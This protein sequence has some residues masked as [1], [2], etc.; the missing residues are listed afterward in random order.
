MGAGSLQHVSQME[1]DLRLELD[2]GRNRWESWHSLKEHWCH[3]KKS[4]YLPRVAT[5]NRIP[6][7]GL[8]NKDI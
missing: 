1:G 6:Q 2:D 7:Y 8:N 4:V 5:H 3:A